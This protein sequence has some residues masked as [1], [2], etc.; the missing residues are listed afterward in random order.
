MGTG[1]SDKLIL[2]PYVRAYRARRLLVLILFSGLSLAVGFGV[3]FWQFQA[4]H[5]AANAENIELRGDLAR[6]EKEASGLAKKL[7]ALQ[8]ER[9][10]DDQTKKNISQMIQSL[11][12]TITELRQDVAFYKN[13]MAPSTASKGLTVQKLSVQANG[14]KGR[15][16]SYKL[17]LAQVA[18]N[19]KYIEG[20]VAVNFIGYRGEQ[21]QIFALK[22]ISD[23]TDLGIKYRFRYFQNIE[24]EL[25]LPDGFIPE[26]IQIVAQSKGKRASRVEETFLWTGSGEVKHVEKKD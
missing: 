3:A 25:T 5:V 13:L 12:S 11:E 19:K 16:Y 26:K 6:V 23:V 2:V 10:I 4:S 24:G 1:N 20:V 18:T 22:E 17:V 14:P 21:K 9:D 7:A 15:R 8:R